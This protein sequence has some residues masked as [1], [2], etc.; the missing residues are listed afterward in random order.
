MVAE[1]IAVSGSAGIVAVFDNGQ[2]EV[3]LASEEAPRV[4][5][6]RVAEMLVR[7]CPDL[8]FFGG[9]EIEAAF[10]RRKRD[11]AIADAINLFMLLTDPGADIDG[12]HIPANIE[13]LEGLLAVNEVADALFRRMLRAPLPPGLHLDRIRPVER[14]GV[15]TGFLWMVA[16][17]QPAL[18]GIRASLEMAF[19]QDFS[20]TPRNRHPDYVAWVQ[21]NLADG[22]AYGIDEAN[23]FQIDWTKAEAIFERLGIQSQLTLWRVQFMLD[24]DILRRDADPPL[25]RDTDWLH[26]VDASDPRSKRD[27]W[28]VG[29]RLGPRHIEIYSPPA[30]SRKASSVDVQ[31]VI[32]AGAHVGRSCHASSPAMQDY[33][34]GKIG[35]RHVFDPRKVAGQLDT[36]CGHIREIA[37]SG[38]DIL[39]VGGGRE[40]RQAVRDAAQRSGQY[41]VT[42]PWQPGLLSSWSA[43]RNSLRKLDRID[44]YLQRYAIVPSRRIRDRRE[45]LW[46]Q[47]GGLR[48]LGTMPA[49]L[50]AI[51]A[52]REQMALAEARALGIKIVALCD[53]DATPA[54]SDIVIPGGLGSASAVRFFC[55]ELGAAARSTNSVTYPLSFGTPFLSLG[56]NHPPA[57]EGVSPISEQADDDEPDEA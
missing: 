5:S 17:V 14:L 40:V 34:F 22:E 44:H 49:L 2:A 38:G 21:R 28:S 47:V 48:G 43:T 7:S 27:F 24:S 29:K 4:V 19:A 41:S 53:A 33:L 12:R 1:R 11:G 3:H 15:V 16:D 13:L 46:S 35:S 25:L 9:N 26:I 55:N 45:E 51:D 20:G 39:F 10:A 8:I 31:Q 56:Y 18:N 32:D 54:A 36:A 30:I 50:I 23:G 6:A 42:G 52:G 57:E 37:R